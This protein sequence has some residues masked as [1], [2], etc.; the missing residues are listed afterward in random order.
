MKVVIEGKLYDTD[1]G[2]LLAS[3]ATTLGSKSETLYKS[4]KLN[5]LFIHTS[6]EHLL[7]EPGPYKSGLGR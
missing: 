5:H 7:G 2:E 1:T 4:P 3:T 6:G